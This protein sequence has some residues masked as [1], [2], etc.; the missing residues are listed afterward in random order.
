MAL[1]QTQKPERSTSDTLRDNE[2][3]GEIH[4]KKKYIRSIKRRTPSGRKCKI[5]GKDASPNYFYC[6]PCHYRISSLE[7]VDGCT[8]RFEEL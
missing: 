5:C 6:P 7:E 2:K 8:I 3:H 4:R 1:L